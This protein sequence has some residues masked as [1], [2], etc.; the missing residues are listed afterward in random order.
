MTILAA[1]VLNCFEGMGWHSSI[2]QTGLQKSEISPISALPVNPPRWNTLRLI[3]LAPSS[4][5]C[6]GVFK[7][8]LDAV[9]D[10]VKYLE[11][12][13]PEIILHG[14]TVV[15]ISISNLKALRGAVL[16]S[17][18]CRSCSCFLSTKLHLGD[19]MLHLIWWLS[20]FWLSVE[21]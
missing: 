4:L 14:L 17:Q 12:P 5:P 21:L 11:K 13:R 8:T 16:P 7:A 3:L 20:E 10:D 1:S 6:N 18:S 9:H 19:R 2:W 15:A